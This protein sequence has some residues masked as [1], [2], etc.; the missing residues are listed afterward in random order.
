MIGFQSRHNQKRKKKKRRRYF[1]EQARRY[2]RVRG[3]I[4]NLHDHHHHSVRMFMHVRCRFDSG[5]NI[6]ETVEQ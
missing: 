6:E 4:I 2:P 5:C 3:T 1:S